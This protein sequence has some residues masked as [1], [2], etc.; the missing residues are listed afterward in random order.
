MT[1]DVTLQ[2]LY[3]F[4]IKLLRNSK[5]IHSTLFRSSRYTSG[6]NDIALVRMAKAAITIM[7][8]VRSIVLPICLDFRPVWDEKQVQG[9]SCGREQSIVPV[10]HCTEISG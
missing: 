3:C 9:G 8:D 1:L 6:A 2:K 7:E 10:L 4:T 5:F